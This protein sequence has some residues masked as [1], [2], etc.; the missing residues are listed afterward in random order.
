M[1]SKEH[2]LCICV[3]KIERDFQ[4][5]LQLIAKPEQSKERPYLEL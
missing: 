3:L 2:T 1:I 4:L 5:Q